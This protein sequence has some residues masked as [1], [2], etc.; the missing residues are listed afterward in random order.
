M[1][2][3]ILGSTGIDYKTKSPYRATKKDDQG[4]VKT[5]SGTADHHAKGI[6]YDNLRSSLDKH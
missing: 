1:Y 4:D 6:K 2:S 3:D 5:R